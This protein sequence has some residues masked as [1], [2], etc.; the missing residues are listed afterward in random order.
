MNDNS[1]RKL[2]AWRPIDTNTF[3]FGVP[4]YPEHIEES[5]WQ[6]DAERMVACGFNTVRMGEFAWHLFEPCEGVYD[7][8]LFDRA[9]DVLANAGIKTILCT[10]TATPPRWLTAKYPEVLRVDKNGRQMSHGSRQHAD[11]IHPLFREFSRRITRAMAE[12]YR[13]NPNVIGWQTD[14]ELNTSMSE[15]YSDA[16]RA[17]FQSF[18]ERKYRSIESLNAAWGGDF[19]ATAYRGFDQVVLPLPNAPVHC[20]PGHVQD[21]HRFLAH[22]TMQFQRDQVEILRQTNADWF[23]FHNMGKLENVDFRNGFASDLDFVGYDVYPFLH[24]EKARIGGHAYMQASQLDLCRGYAGNFIVPEQQSGFGSQVDFSTLTP[25]PGEMRRMAFSSIAHGADGLM[26][27]R[28]RPAHFGAEIYWMGIIDHDNIPRRRFEEAKQVGAEIHQVAEHTLGTTVRID[29]GI[30]SAEFDNDIAH[31]SYP[32]GFPSPHDDAILLH[33]A[34]F[35]RG[36]AA[37]FVHPEDA[38][39]R[40]KVFYVPHWLM[41]KDEWSERLE[42]FARAGGTVIIGARTGSRNTDNH[43]IRVPAPGETL[44]ALTGV[45]VEEFGPLAAPDQEALMGRAPTPHG[46][47]T[48]TARPTE[49]SQRRYRFEFKGQELTA[50]HCYEILDPSSDVDVLAR[51]SNR[52]LEGRAAITRRQVGAGQVLYVGTYLTDELAER[53]TDWVMANGKV[54][55]LIPDL[56]QGIDVTLREK[57]GQK[58]LFVMNTECFE[59]RLDSVAAGVD[60]LTDNRVDGSLTLEGYGCAIIDMS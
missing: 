51:W 58:L 6:Q 35:Q 10:P 39:E 43:V 2:S 52:F 38:L 14:N 4:H 50:G 3:L 16:A 5:W 59:Q 19:W 33:R 54:E 60:L 7:F 40:L 44:T 42:Q 27:F 12:H 36:I 25:E 23:V 22:T 57:D 15:S 29:I 46:E 31:K 53:L 48:T 41:W 13:D 17:E 45:Q 24:E 37:G 30:A 32:I 8:S 26:F 28:W 56:P 55:P 47:F 49:A 20:S 11:T 18:C 34:C 9:I 21:Y 1:E